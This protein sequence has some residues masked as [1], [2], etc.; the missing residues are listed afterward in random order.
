MRAQRIG[1]N[2]RRSRKQPDKKRKTKKELHLVLLLFDRAKI[3]NSLF[4]HCEHFCC[5]LNYIQTENSTTGRRDNVY[6]QQVDHSA[7]I[8][9]S[10]YI[11]E[12]PAGYVMY[13]QRNVPLEFLTA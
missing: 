2:T 6:T 4:P 1:L 10:V 3:V 13:T 9:I 8:C 7:A 11:T 12:K 5:C